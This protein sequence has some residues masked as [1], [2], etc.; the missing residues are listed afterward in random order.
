MYNKD[1]LV[2]TVRILKNNALQKA[3]DKGS[4]AEK[5]SSSSFTVSLV[6]KQQIYSSMSMPHK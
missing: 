6:N 1:K 5:N 2:E 4:K 3:Q